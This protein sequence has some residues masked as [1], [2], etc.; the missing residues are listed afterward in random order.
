VVAGHGASPLSL[1]TDMWQ[2][3]QGQQEGLCGWVQWAQSSRVFFLRVVCHTRIEL[4]GAEG[5]ATLHHAVRVMQR[6][7]TLTC[8]AVQQ[9]SYCGGIWFTRQG[10]TVKTVK[11]VTC[12]WLGKG[13]REALA[14]VLEDHKAGIGASEWIP[15]FSIV[16]IQSGP[17]CYA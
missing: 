13:F 3:F 10:G 16:S 2:A 1:A 12:T 14:K 8:A 5:D 11:F 15:P 4:T 6:C 9:P 7:I 17:V